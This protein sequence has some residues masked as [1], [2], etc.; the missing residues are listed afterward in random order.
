[1]TCRFCDPYGPCQGTCHGLDLGGN[2]LDVCPYCQ[3]KGMVQDDK[4]GIHPC[5]LGC[6]KQNPED[7]CQACVGD[8]CTA[9]EGCVTLSNPCAQSPTQP[10][11]P[12]A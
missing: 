2:K 9:R 12:T 11:D 6:A 1:M 5:P 10:A 4:G 8:Y 3:G 7:H